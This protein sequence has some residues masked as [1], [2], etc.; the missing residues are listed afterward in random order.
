MGIIQDK[1]MPLFYIDKENSS[2]LHFKKIDGSMDFVIISKIH[3]DN[4]NV[5]F[6]D[7]GKILKI[8]FL[9]DNRLFI[10]KERSK[11]ELDI[12]KEDITLKILEMNFI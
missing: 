1:A 2:L 9:D 12:S 3:D 10:I 4:F 11:W 8:S 7:S 5:I 6:E